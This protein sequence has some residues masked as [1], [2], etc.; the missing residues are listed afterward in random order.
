MIRIIW[1]DRW[2]D[3]KRVVLHGDAPKAYENAVLQAVR[4]LGLEISGEGTVPRE[5]DLW[6]GG[7]PEA[8]MELLDASCVLWVEGDD[9]P[10]AIGRLHAIVTPPHRYIA[11]PR[12]AEAEP[13]RRTFPRPFSW[14]EPYDYGR[15]ALRHSA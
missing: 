13:S 9:V 5:G 15:H 8:G 1:R 6:I 4:R 14:Q 3:L 11:G 2:F 10:S 7:R 12:L